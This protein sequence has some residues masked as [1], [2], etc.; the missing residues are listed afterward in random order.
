MEGGPSGAAE[1]RP[2]ETREIEPVPALHEDVADGSE[3]DEEER[4]RRRKEASA[5]ALTLEIVGDLPHAEVKPP[6]NVL[7]VCKLNP[8]T[9]S[10]DLELIFSRF[11]AISSCEV[12]KDKKTGDSLQYAFIE[13]EDKASAEQAYVKMQNVL[14]DDRRI[15]VDFSQS[16]SRLHGVW[17]KQ[18]ARQQGRSA[19]RHAPREAHSSRD[20]YERAQSR[21]RPS[22]RDRARR[23]YRS[24]HPPRLRHDD[25]HRSR[26]RR[27]D[28]HH[29]RS[30]HDDDDRSWSRRTHDRGSG[31]RHRDDWRSS[32]YDERGARWHRSADAEADRWSHSRPRRASPSDSP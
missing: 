27:Y 5:A 22:D 32:R 16:V 7:F 20:R 11:G 29:S 19:E 31:R 23:D 18:R 9:R 2:H 13:F 12:M 17:L 25:E 4:E 1:P 6:E 26:S 21:S 3:T 30:R 15:W 10:E 8:V 24:E 14:I 28:D